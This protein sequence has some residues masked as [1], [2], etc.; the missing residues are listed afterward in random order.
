L[1]LARRRMRPDGLA[2]VLTN[3]DGLA[4]AI[5]AMQRAGFARVRTITWDKKVPGLGGGLRHRTEYILVGLLPG[6]RTL[7]GEDLVSVASVGSG[8]ANRYP[9]QKPDGLGRALA[10]I[11][12][13]GPSDVVLDPFCGSGSLLVG[14]RERGAT[15]LGC[16]VAP[17]A[18]KAATARLKAGQTA[19]ITRRPPAKARAPSSL[20][21]RRRRAAPAYR[22]SAQ[23]PARPTRRR[24]R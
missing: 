18:I 24:S 5:R 1:A 10:G 21:G 20:E 6:S 7:R 13:I 9:T 22:K 23:A 14:A 12:V 11:A 4:D 19:P 15:V 2:F 8:T 17:G 3:G 16:D